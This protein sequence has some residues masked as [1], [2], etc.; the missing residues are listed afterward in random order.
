M[1]LSSNSLKKV[2]GVFDDCVA[3]LGRLEELKKGLSTQADHIR[4]QL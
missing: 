2:N 4:H 3:C 1:T